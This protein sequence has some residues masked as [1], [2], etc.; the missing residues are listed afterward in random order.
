MLLIKT[1]VSETELNYFYVIKN[2]LNKI[3]RICF[4]NIERQSQNN[5]SIKYTYLQ[6]TKIYK[7]E[8]SEITEM[9]KNIK[10]TLKEELNL[11]SKLNGIDTKKDYDALMK[12][13]PFKINYLN[14]YEIEYVLLKKGI[15]CHKSK[16]L[17]FY[18][19]TMYY[20]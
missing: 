11:I 12:F 4:I 7:N 3:I 17:S 9:N 18:V 6:T 5:G 20:K 14:E 16:K 13:N 10:E 2:S 15:K 8:T 19:S 1:I